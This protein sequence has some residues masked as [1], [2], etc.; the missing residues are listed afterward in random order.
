MGSTKAQDHTPTVEKCRADVATWAR[1]MD[2]HAYSNMPYM[3]VVAHEGEVL[4]CDGIDSD[5]RFKSIYEMHIRTTEIEI[6]WRLDD[7][8]KRHNLTHEFLLEDAQGER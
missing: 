5:P 6:R 8:V 3:E 7:F 4:K 1:T 2:L